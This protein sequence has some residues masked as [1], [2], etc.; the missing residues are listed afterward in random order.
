MLGDDLILVQVDIAKDLSLCSN[1]GHPVSART[2]SV[3]ACRGRRRA[4]RKAVFCSDSM[5]LIADGHA[6][7]N[8]MLP[9]SSIGRMHSL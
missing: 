4:M 3:R 1:G 7:A 9:Y 6:M 8:A 5:R 2:K